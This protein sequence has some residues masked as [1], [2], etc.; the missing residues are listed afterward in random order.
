M[1]PWICTTCCVEYPASAEPPA[2]CPICQDE[3]QYVNPGG[4]SWTRMAEIATTRHVDWRELGPGLFG[5]G[6]TPG[7]GIGQRMLFA[8]GVL[9]DCVPLVDDAVVEKLKAAGGVRAMAISHPHFY[10]A[11][12]SWSEKLGGVP[13]YLHADDR[14]HVMRPSPHIRHWTGESIEL[15]PGMTLVRCGGH[16]SG[17]SVLH[18]AQGCEGR[19]ALF[20]GDTIQVAADP[21]WVSFLRSYPNMIPLPASKVTAIV[22]AVRPYPFEK[23]YGGW[24]ERVVEADANAVVERSAERYISAL[25]G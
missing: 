2:A 22:K 17:S 18:W 11:M 16:F 25:A 15:A 9:W 20:A 23:L 5:I 6:V 12:V 3:R 10:A 8:G 19:G 13:I 7:I 4:Q 14:E 24:W 21:H 1:Q